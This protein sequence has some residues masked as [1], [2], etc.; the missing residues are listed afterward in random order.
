MVQEVESTTSD[1]EATDG[2]E[3]GSGIPAAPEDVTEKE[4]LVDPDKIL[5]DYKTEEK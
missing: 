3:L 5:N 2:P 4:K 1:L